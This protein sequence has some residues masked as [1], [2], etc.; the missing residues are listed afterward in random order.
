MEFIDYLIVGGGLAAAKCAAKLRERGAKGRVAIVGAETHAPY[1]RPP[2]SKG[3]LLGYDTVERLYVFP[4]AFYEERSIERLLGVAAAAADSSA[5]AVTLTDGRTLNYGTMLIST[6]TSPVHLR[7]P[8][9]ELSNIFYL[10][11]LD[12]ALAILN[13]LG[14]AKEAVI[15]GAGFIGMELAAAFTE[16]GLKTTM[17]VREKGLFTKLGSPRLS[18]FFANKYKAHGVEVIYEDEVAEFEGSGKVETLITK[19][20]RRLTADMAAVGIGVAAN[21][22]WLDGSGI[23]VDRGVVVDEYLRSKSADVFAAGDVAVYYDPIFEKRR[24]VEHWDNAIRQG[25]L[26]A[27]N[28]LGEKQAMA[29]VAYFFSDMFDLSWEWL[30]D[31]SDS[32]ET[33]QRGVLDGD[34]AAIFYLRQDKMRAAFL[35]MPDQGDRQWVERQIKSGHD[36]G[37]NKKELADPS[38]PLEEIAS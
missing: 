37:P 20:G 7:A 9:A 38:F 6:G 3:L 25:E 12:D 34:S 29:Y 26:A 23:E 19:G 30:G 11:T 18:E 28:M 21:T 17:L 8:G 16:K 2:L 35:L 33:V 31:N 1:N 24:R 36:F 15:V 5:K 13:Q 22:D 10:R 32:D 14:S 27:L 4:E